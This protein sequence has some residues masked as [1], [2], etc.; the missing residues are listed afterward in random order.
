[1]DIKE[2]IKERVD[3]IN[4]RRLLDELLKIVELEHEI[5]HVHEL[6]DP[7]KN[8]IDEGILD[9]EAGNLLSNSEA[10]QQV[11]EWLKK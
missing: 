7:E 1:M 2:K 3:N 5:E 10:S 8:A 4:D 6:S 11:M 9:A